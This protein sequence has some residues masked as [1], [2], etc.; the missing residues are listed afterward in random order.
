M[1]KLLRGDLF[2]S[3][4]KLFACLGD[5]DAQNNAKGLVVHTWGRLFLLGYSTHWSWSYSK[6]G[7]F[8]L[9]SWHLMLLHH[10]WLAG[11][12]V[13][14]SQYHAGLLQVVHQHLDRLQLIIHFKTF[15]YF[16]SMRSMSVLFSCIVS[17]PY[18]NKACQFFQFWVL[19][20]RVVLK[21][22]IYM[23][24]AQKKSLGKIRA[25]WPTSF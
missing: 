15:L 5:K 22:D 4:Y 11:P 10:I 1:L 24:R 14:G 25:P 16:T 2:P 6:W 7:C 13:P 18:R 21:C 20:K 8:G 12:G 3:G 23:Y 9:F 17:V 19:K